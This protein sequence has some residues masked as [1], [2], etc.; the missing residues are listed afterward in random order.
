LGVG[1]IVNFAYDEDKDRDLQARDLSQLFP[2]EITRIAFMRERVLRRYEQQ[3]IDLM[4]HGV[5]DNARY[6]LQE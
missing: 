4:Q 1:I 3:F 2:W 5:T 6:V